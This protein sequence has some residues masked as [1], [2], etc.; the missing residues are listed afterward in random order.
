[1][2]IRRW[3]WV[4]PRDWEMASYKS[5]GILIACQYCKHRTLRATR[6]KYYTLHVIRYVV[7]VVSKN[8]WSV[9]HCC[10]CRIISGRINLYVNTVIIIYS[11]SCACL[12]VRNLI[13]QIR[14]AELR[15]KWYYNNSA[16][17]LLCIYVSQ[18]AVDSVGVGLRHVLFKHKYI[19]ILQD[20]RARTVS[21]TRQVII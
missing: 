12:F 10:K 1:M 2:S 7:L 3:W 16:A 20:S 15:P 13:I 18:K 14:C 17:E 11:E 8:P 6:T 9:F 21:R 4:G 19:Y 5:M